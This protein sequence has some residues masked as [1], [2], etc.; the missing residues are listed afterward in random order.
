MQGNQI[1]LEKQ[2]GSEI[3][4]L[5]EITF[6]FDENWHTFEI[7]GYDNILNIYMDDNLLIKYKDTENPVLSGRVA[8]EI[9][10]ESKCCVDCE[11]EYESHFNCYFEYIKKIKIT[12]K[13]FYNKF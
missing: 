4:K 2:H 5:K 12:S 3:H 11:K 7:R 13:K 10:K 6:R 1:R 9:I 8:F